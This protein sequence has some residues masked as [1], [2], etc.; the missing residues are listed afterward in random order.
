MNL[1]LMGAPGAGK[2][3]QAEI[4]SEKF[5]IPAIS[6]GEIL[7]ASIKAGTE[8]GKTAKSYI[9]KGDLVPDDVVIGII[10]EHLSSDACKNG[11]ILDGFPRS[12]AQAEALETLGVKIDAVLTIEVEDERIV[13]RMGGRR[14]CPACGASY[15]VSYNPPAKE[16]ICD[17]CFAE[18]IIRSDDAAETVRNRLVTYHNQTE[19]LKAF[20]AERGLLITVEG[21]EEL[22]DTTRL[23]SEAL[24]KI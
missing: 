24:A 15:H 13:A 17:K 10:K 8:L 4:I 12:V 5:Q 11:F 14:V 20:Y 3:T 18:L 9:D 21:Q 16:G 1:I 2:G 19:P 23:V 6:T 7:R 22:D